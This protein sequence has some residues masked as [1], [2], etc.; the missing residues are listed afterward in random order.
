ML[1]NAQ[2]ANEVDNVRGIEMGGG[3]EVNADYLFC[4]PRRTPAESGEI[5]P[6]AKRHFRWNT[7]LPTYHLTSC[8]NP[9]YLEVGRLFATF[10]S[11]A[12]LCPIHYPPN[13]AE[14]ADLGFLR[15][16]RM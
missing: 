16:P 7:Y 3:P 1:S 6:G 4:L 13:N 9:R 10:A 15:V 2:T 8:S 5:K 11:A 12:S 14:H